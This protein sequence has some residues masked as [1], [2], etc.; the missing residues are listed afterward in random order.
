MNA[1]PFSSLLSDPLVIRSHDLFFQFRPFT[2]TPC[3]ASSVPSDS[4]DLKEGENVHGQ[5]L[6]AFKYLS[7]SS[8]SS[9][10]GKSYQTPLTT[11]GPSHACRTKQRKNL[12]VHSCA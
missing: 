3:S 4:Y 12:L 8:P 1:L 2:P 10:G 9:F 5:N 6:V 11:S 7:L